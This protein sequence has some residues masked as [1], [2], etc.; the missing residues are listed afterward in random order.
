MSAT[1][2]YLAVIITLI[3]GASIGAFTIYGDEDPVVEEIVPIDYDTA[4]LHC[5]F[6]FENVSG[7]STTCDIDPS[8]GTHYSIRYAMTTNDSLLRIG[9][10]TWTGH[11]TT[12][13]RSLDSNI[14]IYVSGA[15]AY[16]EDARADYFAVYIVPHP[17]ESL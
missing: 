4:T 2:Y 9:D 6:N 15:D 16:P 17:T 5:W 7:L 8:M 10:D 11:S 3:L 13:W 12:G 14:T 1:S